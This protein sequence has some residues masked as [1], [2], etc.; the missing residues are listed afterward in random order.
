MEGKG[1][2]DCWQNVVKSILGE[3]GKED[4]EGGEE[5]R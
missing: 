5:K 1:E 2:E 3:D 4:E